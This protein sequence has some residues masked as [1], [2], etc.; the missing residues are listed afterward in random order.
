MR[1]IRTATGRHPRRQRRR[2]ESP[3][4]RLVGVGMSALLAA[5]T[6]SGS[7]A[8]PVVG[9]VVSAPADGELARNG[10]FEAGTVG[11]RT[12]DPENQLLD[13]VPD[14][15]SGSAARVRAQVP[16]TVVLNDSPN[17][18][19]GISLGQTYAVR[20]WVRIT[21]PGSMG[22]LRVRE[23]TDGQVTTHSATFRAQNTDWQQV[24]LTFATSSK[25][26]S[27]DLN[28]LAWKLPAGAGLVV[29][30]VSMESV[31]DPGSVA[32][33]AEP[34]PRSARGIPRCGVLVGSALGGNDDPTA[35]ERRV[36]NTLQI[37]R[38][39]WDAATVDSAVD[40]ARTDLAAGRT[41][42]LSFKLPFSWADMAAG[43]G[44][45]WAQDLIRRL[46]QLPGPV[47]IAFHHEPEGDGN[48]ADWVA[49]QRRLAPMVKENTRN[50]AYTMILTGWNQFY[51]DPQYALDALWP[52][53]GLVDLLGF[54]IYNE[55]GKRR[56]GRTNRTMLDL[57]AMYYSKISAFARS[58][59]TAWGLAEVGYTDEAA[60]TDP[61]WLD[62]TYEQIGQFGGVTMTYF[63]SRLNS[64]GASWEI[65]TRQKR[66]AFRDV[67]QR[68]K[69]V[70]GPTGRNR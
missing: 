2:L 25:N 55:Y 36:G 12:N 35:F 30:D 70:T 47:W 64:G 58:H 38:T 22:Q 43:R 24:T 69:T 8:P 18:V 52:G 51:G 32:E 20:A 61:R 14:G 28:V 56:N 37:R 4:R 13:S 40:T 63:N 29:D 16:G 45:R 26:G 15:R 11:W 44:D 65:T 17:T 53:D 33:P 10:G 42:W 21:T 34:C 9:P 31:P 39:Y 41:P 67:L 54:D 23:V 5:T 6:L 27:L 19:R 66:D 59:D 7:T 46:G 3:A 60:A 62:R 1:R 57:G 50:V 49:M 68:A 48:I